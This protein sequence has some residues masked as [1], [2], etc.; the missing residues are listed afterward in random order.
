MAGYREA[1]DAAWRPCSWQQLEQE[2]R[3]AEARRQQAGGD[4]SSGSS[5]SSGRSSSSSGSG[6]DGWE[7]QLRAPVHELRELWRR[8]LEVRALV[9]MM[10]Q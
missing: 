7:V 4:G 3:V 2:V 8:R 6:P 9:T 5:S 10:Q 1:A